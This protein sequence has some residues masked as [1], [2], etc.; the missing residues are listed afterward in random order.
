MRQ[1]SKPFG[2]IYLDFRPHEWDIRVL[3]S[4]FVAKRPRQHHIFHH[5]PQ[6]R[7]LFQNPS[8]VF[9]SKTP[10][11]QITQPNCSSH[12]KTMTVIWKLFTELHLR[13]DRFVMPSYRTNKN[14]GIKRLVRTGCG[15]ILQNIQKPTERKHNLQFNT[16]ITKHFCII[17]EPIQNRF[18]WR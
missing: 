10:S 7:Q 1:F 3:F 5:I 15:E 18:R 14:N 13:L 12:R 9:G 8:L 17:C 4:R 2:S 6:K 16:K 11:Q